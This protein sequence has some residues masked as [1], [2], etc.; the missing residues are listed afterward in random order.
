M[1]MANGSFGSR[2]GQ[3]YKFSLAQA[4]RRAE[5]RK[6]STSA[7]TD[8]P[9]A[10][11]T[12]E[13]VREFLSAYLCPWC[14]AGPFKVVALHTNKFHGVGRIELRDAAGIPRSSK[15]TPREYSEKLAGLHGERLAEMSAGA[16]EAARRKY[17]HSHSARATQANQNFRAAERFELEPEVLYR[18]RAGETMKQISESMGISLAPIRKILAEN[19]EGEKTHAR[20]AKI[21]AS[22][23]GS[24]DAR[25]AGSRRAQLERREEFIGTYDAF[26]HSE[27]GLNRMAE[28]YGVARKAVIARLKK[29]GC[30]VPDLRGQTEAYKA[31]L[32]SRPSAQPRFCEIDG[33]ERRHVALGLCGTHYARQK[34]T[35][36]NNTK[37]DNDD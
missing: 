1:Q 10:I 8:D 28:K 21:V 25:D 16:F 27:E 31:A 3:P 7:G 12:P 4:T 17:G 22:R 11:L 9:L 24:R 20:A 26:G 32:R 18:Y 19:G 37:G 23:P 29:Y 15:I 30:D 14:G 6:D 2:N 35:K 5:A 13:R 36:S 33:C 34:K